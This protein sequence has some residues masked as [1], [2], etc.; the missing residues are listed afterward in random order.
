ML[1]NVAQ[2]VI[3]YK[4]VTENELGVGYLFSNAVSVSCN[5]KPG[6]LIVL[7]KRIL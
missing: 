3:I 2:A 4:L 1:T 5:V 7:I 6:P